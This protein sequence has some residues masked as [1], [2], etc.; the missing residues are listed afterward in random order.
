MIDKKERAKR[1]R[2]VKE[3]S[4]YLAESRAGLKREMAAQLRSQ[5]EGDRDECMDS[6]ELAFDENAREISMM[7]SEREE[8]KFGQIN[9]ALKRMALK[10]YGLCQTCGLEVNEER[11]RA[12]PFTLLCCDCQQERERDA[13]RQG[14]TER[15]EYR[16]SADTSMHEPEEV[17]PGVQ[18]KARH[19]SMLS[20]L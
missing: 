2:F 9:A 17:G 12:L 1:L 5:R 15:P 4:D 6:C 3:M 11:L 20:L 13:K 18:L 7:L 14:Q 8:V 16:V 19:E 10:Q